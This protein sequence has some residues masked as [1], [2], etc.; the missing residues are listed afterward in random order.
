MIEQTDRSG[1]NKT[2]S[3]IGNISSQQ[4]GY[5]VVGVLSYHS[6]R[7]ADKGF[8]SLSRSESHFYSF[9]NSCF[10]WCGVIGT[11]NMRGLCLI[12]ERRIS[13]VTVR[14]SVRPN[15]SKTGII[16]WQIDAVCLCP[17]LWNLGIIQKTAG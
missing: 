15:A 2:L 6:A 16:L 14:K 12:F 13:G 8:K 9:T 3:G 11:G 10:S 17:F 5:A 1:K 4:L 7:I